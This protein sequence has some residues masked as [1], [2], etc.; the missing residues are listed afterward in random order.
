MSDIAHL[1]DRLAWLERR[2]RDA[3]AERRGSD[4]HPDDPF[5]GLYLSDEAID[6]LLDARRRPFAP[7]AR[8]IAAGRL[9]N[10][11]ATAGLTEV[12]VELLLVAVAPDVD[13]RFEQFYGYLN[14]DVTRRRATAGLALRLCGVP[15]AS[16]A[17]RARLDADAPLVV[18][19][20]LAV[21][22]PDRPFLSRGLRVPDRVVN[23]LLG[24]DRPDPGLAEVA[25]LGH[26]AVAVPG[27][28]RL[29]APL[30]AGVRLLHLREHPG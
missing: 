3:V 1:L 8:P 15:E 9:G 17:G 25:H 23:H 19:G 4:P 14:D 20:L 30:R 10:L 7:F 28:D 6:E 26:A 12:D 11:A 21:E 29:A 18:A 24:D 27:A 22:E 2:I 13:S 16:A 5:R